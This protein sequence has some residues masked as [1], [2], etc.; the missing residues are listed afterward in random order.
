MHS[1][2][3]CYHSLQ[4]LL[5]SSLLSTNLNIEIF[6]NIILP[7]VLCGRETWSL[8]LREECRLTVFENRVLGRIFGPKRD[9]I[10]GSGENYIMSSLMICTPHPILFG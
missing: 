8:I 4:N 10:K 9:K 3:A 7:V 5:S 6:K 1:A 2:N